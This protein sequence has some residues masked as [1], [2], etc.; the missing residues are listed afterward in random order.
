MATPRLPK[1]PKNLK[2]KQSEAVKFVNLTPHDIHVFHD[3]ILRECTI[4]PASGEVARLAE[5]IT[6]TGKEAGG[7]ELYAI[8][9]NSVVV[10]VPKPHKNTYYIVSAICK[11]LLHSRDDVLCPVRMIKSRDRSQVLGC[12]GL[13]Y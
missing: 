2:Q 3:E 7:I 8:K 13:G 4:I 12:R 10:G 6:P 11:M 9:H 5:V 1:M